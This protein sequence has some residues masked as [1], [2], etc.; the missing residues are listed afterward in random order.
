L[1]E[2]AVNAH[3]LTTSGAE[4][5]SEDDIRYLLRNLD[6]RTYAP[7]VETLGRCYPIDRF[8]QKTLDAAEELLRGNE[9]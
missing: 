6:I 4:F 3:V 9:A 7:A 1:A 8:P 2:R 5:H